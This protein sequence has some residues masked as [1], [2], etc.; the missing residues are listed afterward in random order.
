[1]TLARATAVLALLLLPAVGFAGVDLDGDGFAAPEDCDDND[2]AINPDAAE[3]CN[4]VDDDCDGTIDEDAVDAG[5]YFEDSDG[6]GFGDP[7]SVIISCIVPPGYVADAS[8]CD[9]ADPLSN[10][11][12]YEYCSDGVD[13]DCDGTADDNCDDTDG[14][15]L[16]DADEL[17]LGTNKELADTDGDGLDDWEELFVYELD[18]ND[19]DTDADGLS[20]GDEVLIHGTDPT[21]TPTAA[22]RATATKWRT[23]ATRSTRPTTK[24]SWAR[25]TA[26]ATACPTK[27]KRRWAP[28]PSTRTP[29]AT[30]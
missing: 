25:Q 29:T 21:A 15:G 26:T 1:M 28:T 2:P 7:A 13:Q 3:L 5:R 27:T 20:D 10:P 22:A 9:D 11:D 14:D 16:S 24:R 19:P 18:P 6:D 4:G 12:A 30:G 23:A 8:D 17:E